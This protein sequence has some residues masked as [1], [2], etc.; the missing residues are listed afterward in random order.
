MTDSNP[1]SQRPPPPLPWTTAGHAPIPVATLPY[2]AALLQTRK[3]SIL[4]AI[5]TMSIVIAS[6]SVLSSLISG[7]NAASFYFMS[8]FAPSMA[9]AS[10]PATAPTTIPASSS[11]GGSGASSFSVSVSPM[12]SSNA[13]TPAEVNAIV[14]S[15]QLASGNTLTPAHVKGLK[16]ALAGPNQQLVIAGT[17]TSTIVSSATVDAS[18]NAA[19]S[20]PGGIVNISAT[21]QTT[22]VPG[23]SATP[24]FN[25]TTIACVLTLLDALLSIG[26]AVFLFVSA[27]MILRH[28]TSGRRQH[29]IF[30]ALKIPLVLAGSAAATWMYSDLFG[31]MIAGAPG[32]SAGMMRMVAIGWGSG[33]AVLGLIYP[34]ALLI[35]L[36]TPTVRE[37]FGV[38]RK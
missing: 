36:N 24:T 10:V 18:G 13:L 31:S 38:A 9:A 14:Q 30:A 4:T 17:G 25:V 12:T 7:C 33:F 1:P 2:A 8:K 15:A 26:L 35:A 27:L 37:Y 19:I 6:L 11:T 5:G 16:G 28:G 23:M 21:G 32:G 20:L 34:I 29:L 22:T 3:P